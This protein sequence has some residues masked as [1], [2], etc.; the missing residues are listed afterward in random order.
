MQSDKDLGKQLVA[1][2]SEQ[3]LL[4]WRSVLTRLEAGEDVAAAR[5]EAFLAGGK[6]ARLPV[7]RKFYD[8]SHARKL[9]AM[10]AASVGRMLAPWLDRAVEYAVHEDDLPD[11]E[12]PLQ[13]F[14]AMLVRAE[15]VA[16]FESGHVPKGYVGFTVNPFPDEGVLHGDLYELSAAGASAGGVLKVYKST[17]EPFTDAERKAAE[18]GIHKNFYANA[19]SDG[20]DEDEWTL[21]L[22]DDEDDCIRVRVIEEESEDDD[23]GE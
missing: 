10:D 6:A 14:I 19:D 15:Y 7:A 12:N 9:A 3:F 18:A 8:R 4:H 1:F 22:E 11:P 2:A 13:H 20:V 16:I 5:Q 23:D 21:E 17:A